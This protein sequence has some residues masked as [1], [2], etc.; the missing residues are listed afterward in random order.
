MSGSPDGDD[1]DDEDYQDEDD[2]DDEDDDHEDDQDYPP[3]GQHDHTVKPDDDEDEMDDQLSV[4][5]PLQRY[6]KDLDTFNAY[7]EEYGRE[8][9]QTFKYASLCL[10]ALND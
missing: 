2:E 3:N 10:C 5:P 7:L 4:A 9:Y 1:E 8:T 6:H